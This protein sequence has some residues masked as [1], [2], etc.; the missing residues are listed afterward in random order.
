[1][2][3]PPERKSAGIL[4]MLATMMCFICLDS[5]MK[6]ALQ[7]YSLLE[8]TWGRFF[9]ATVFAAMLCGRSLPQLIKTRQ[10]GLQ[11]L[12]SLMLAITTGLFNAGIHLEP[13]PTGTTIMFMTPIIVTLLS[14][15]FLRERVGWRR[16]TG[17]IIGFCGAMVVM[18]FWEFGKTSVGAGVFFLFAAAF[19]NAS[20]QTIT[21]PLRSENPLTTLLYSAALGAVVTTPFVPLHWQWPDATGWALFLGSGFFGCLGHWC[22]IR[23][24]SAAP[25]A[26]ITP[27]YYSSLIWATIVGFVVWG[28]LPHWNTLM[29][30]ALIVGSG[31]YIFW[32]ERVLGLAEKREVEAA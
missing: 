19:T 10:P 16:W 30:A 24:F 6:Y 12:R 1:M 21:R 5:L 9:F 23:A 32:R 29:G 13:L 20:Y 18:R 28:D 26:V 31:L 8:V 25:A 22:L 14:S 7:T 3:H 17:I 27:F 15:L 11:A 4:W 2:N